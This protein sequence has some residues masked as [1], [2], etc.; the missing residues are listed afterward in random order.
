MIDLHCHILPG[1]DDG[2]ESAAAACRM[3]ERALNSG[4]RT[5]VATPHCNLRGERSNYRGP[6]LERQFAMLRALLRQHGLPLRV[7]P[8]AEVFAH[9]DNI[10]SLLEEGRLMTLNR[11][12]YLLVE[13]PFSAPGQEIT[14]ILDAV[15]RRGCVPVVAHPERYAAVQRDPRLAALWFRRGYVIQ[16]N[17][18]SLL[19]L[20]GRSSAAMARE[21]LHRGLVHVIASDAH[22]PDHRTAGFRSLLPL[23]EQRCDP[24]YIELLLRG[25]PQR[26]IRNK[27]IPLPEAAREDVLE[28]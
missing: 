12:R 21:L 7:L 17:K 6:A 28:D 26:I 15:A 5:V 3:A 10:R 14:A 19:G 25:N 1:V 11:S 18:G 23:L 20:L 22:D 13:F 2:A 27:V 16:V 9:G 24:T 4:V 8:G